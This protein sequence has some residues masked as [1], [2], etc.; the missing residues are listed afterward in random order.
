MYTFRDES[1]WILLLLF[2]TVKLPKAWHSFTNTHTTTEHYLQFVGVCMCVSVFFKWEWRLYKLQQQMEEK[3]QNRMD[4]QPE[5]YTKKR[6]YNATLSI[7]NTCWIINS[8][9]QA[10][11]WGMR[12]R[13]LPGI[14]ADMSKHLSGQNVQNWIPLSL[15]AVGRRSHPD[16]PHC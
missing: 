9:V 8:R 15:P 2:S 16:G 14:L 12:M 1:M 11:Y 5:S 4:A 6:P 7:Y 10:V 13:T 3:K